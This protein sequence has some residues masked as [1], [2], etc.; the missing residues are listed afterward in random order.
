MFEAVVQGAPAFVDC[1][2]GAATYLY[3]LANAGVLPENSTWNE[4]EYTR[5]VTTKQIKENPEGVIAA[6][7]DLSGRLEQ[8]VP[9]VH[10]EK[11]K[12]TDDARAAIIDWLNAELRGEHGIAYVPAENAEDAEGRTILFDTPATAA[13]YLLVQNISYSARAQ[14]V[15][16]YEGKPTWTTAGDDQTPPQTATVYAGRRHGQMEP[17]FRLL[18]ADIIRKASEPRMST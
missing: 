11:G 5:H 17:S 14:D 1:F 13:L 9:P 10:R 4:W 15:S 2:G 7:D 3:N 16:M 12:E 8:V 6:L 18:P